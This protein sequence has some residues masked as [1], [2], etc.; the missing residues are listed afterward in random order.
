MP[1]LAA[2]QASLEQYSDDAKADNTK[3]AYAKQWH[4]FQAWCLTKALGAVPAGPG[5]VALY[6]TACANAGLAL[7]TLKQAQA[8]ITYHHHET[9]HASPCATPLVKKA[10]QGIR[11]RLGAAQNQKHPLDADQIR[12]MYEVLPS[13]LLGVRDRALIGL[14]FSGAFRRGELVALDVSDLA[15]VRRGLEARVRRSKTDQEGRGLTKVISRGSDASTCAVRAVRD[16]LK[17]ARIEDGPV[18]RSVDRHGNVSPRRLSA[19]SVAL[20]LKR[21]AAAAGIPVDDIAGHSLRAGFVTEAKKHGADDAAI[22]DQT[23]HQSIAMV[24][25]YHRRAKKWEKPASE[26]LGF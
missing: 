6:L 1:E 19:Q 4:Q 2:L 22:M 10:W 12:A 18:F 25:R 7:A 15:F 3:L 17:L 8:A 5:T 9:G 14:G 24:Q 23:G 20:V 11:R 13:G 26:K 21:A 16:W